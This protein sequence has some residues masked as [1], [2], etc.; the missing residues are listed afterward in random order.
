MSD[1]TTSNLGFAAFLMLKGYVLV[2]QPMR[3]AQ[4]KFLFCFNIN[5]EVAN[6]LYYEYLNSEFNKFDNNVVTLKRTL[7]AKT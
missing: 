3:D 6:N 1:K 2:S 5:Q 7:M 4:N